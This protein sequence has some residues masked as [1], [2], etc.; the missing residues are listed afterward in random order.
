MQARYRSDYAGEFIVLETQWS[1]GTK[2]QKREWVANPIENHHISGR[3]ACVGSHIDITKFDHNML[4]RHRGGL[5]GS[6]KLQT[7]GIGSIAQSMRLDFC[8]ESNTDNLQ[9]LIDNNYYEN[10][11]VYTTNKNCLA[12][13]GL[14][15][16]IPYRTKL[17]DLCQLIYLAAFDGHKEIFMLGYSNDTPIESQNWIGEIKTVFDAYSG[18]KFYLI[19]EKTNLPASWLDSAN[20]LTLTHRE[21]ISYCDV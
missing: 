11:I 20:V 19:G 6:K 14:F 16:I 4:Q 21:F 7:Y 2:K 1:G 8:V 18:T 15:Y 12:W 9:K 10:N 13:P 3:A 17:L 5:L